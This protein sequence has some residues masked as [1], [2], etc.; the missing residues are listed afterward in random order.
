LCIMHIFTLEKLC[1]YFCEFSA[2]FQYSNKLILL[3]R[4]EGKYKRIIFS[5]YVKSSVFLT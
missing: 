3:S 2:R 5:G 1:I 4:F